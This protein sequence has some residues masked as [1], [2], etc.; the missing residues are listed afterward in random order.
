[1]RECIDTK[2]VRKPKSSN[3]LPQ[4]K[5]FVKSVRK[6][7]ENPDSHAFDECLRFLWLIKIQ[8]KQKEFPF[9]PLFACTYVCL[10]VP[11]GCTI[12]FEGVGALNQNLV[13]VFYVK[14]R[15]PK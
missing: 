7:Y 3:V 15:N 5:N 2:S 1:M 6:Q 9:V 12:T 4:R 11:S 13:D 14:Y 10:Y 8:N